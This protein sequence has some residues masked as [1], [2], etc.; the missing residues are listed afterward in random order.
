MGALAAVAYWTESGLERPLHRGAALTYPEEQHPAGHE[1]RDS[2]I[3]NWVTSHAKLGHSSPVKS[4]LLHSKEQV[5]K[6]K[7]KTKKPSPTCPGF[8]PF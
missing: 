2:G 3:S 4:A 5:K 8:I 6:K 7:K 1:L